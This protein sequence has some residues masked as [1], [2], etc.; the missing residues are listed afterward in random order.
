MIADAGA[1]ARYCPHSSRI[2]CWRVR[3]APT[4]FTIS[5][6]LRVSTPIVNNR[7]GPGM[8]RNS[9]DDRGALVLTDRINLILN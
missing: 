1:V 7:A 6:T 9:T 2:I 8:Y 4:E 3:K 5:T